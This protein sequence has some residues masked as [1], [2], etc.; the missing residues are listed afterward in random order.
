MKKIV[1]ALLFLNLIC[2]VYLMLNVETVKGIARSV[3]SETDGAFSGLTKVYAQETNPYREV[4]NGEIE[5]FI[6]VEEVLQLPE[7][8]NGC[9]ITS[10]TSLFNFFGYR[11]SKLDMADH[12]LP[13]EQFKTINNVLYGPDPHKAY[14]GNPRQMSGFFTYAPPI[15]QAAKTYIEEVGAQLEPVDLSGSSREEIMM[16]L[17]EGNP[18]VIW[19]TLDLSKKKVNYSWNING[20]NEKFDAPTN[21]HAVVL[22][23][24]VGDKVHVMN[25]LHGQITYDADA[26]F[27]SYEDLGSHAMTVK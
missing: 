1:T 25:P 5:V 17:E 12:Y 3:L 27:A 22:N 8:P 13:K 26:F 7:L 11:V 20:T 15:V 19:V 21:L 18:V 2:V 24:Y 9:E 16:E 14:A 6:P 4:S 23:G 10:L